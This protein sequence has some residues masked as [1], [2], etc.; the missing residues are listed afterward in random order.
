MLS[1]PSRQSLGGLGDIA[2]S[3]DTPAPR[4]PSSAPVS[5]E[6]AILML[7]GVLHLLGWIMNRTAAKWRGPKQVANV[8]VLP[9]GLIA[10]CGH[11][12][13]VRSYDMVRC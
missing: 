8:S 4:P 1:F 6:I 12:A 5:H 2:I 11:D 10:R 9:Y 7:H 13:G 3:F